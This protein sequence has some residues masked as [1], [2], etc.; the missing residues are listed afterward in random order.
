MKAHYVFEDGLT[1]KR[2]SSEDRRKDDRVVDEA[3]S[4][5]CGINSE[6]TPP[7]I[8]I[9]NR[10]NE[11]RDG[12]GPLG[13]Q[14]LGSELPPVTLSIGPE[15][16]EGDGEVVQGCS[17]QATDLHIRRKNE[18]LYSR[19]GSGRSNS[20]SRHQRKIVVKVS[21]IFHQVATVSEQPPRVPGRGV[22]LLEGGT[23]PFEHLASARFMTTR[24]YKDCIPMERYTIS[25]RARLR[26][27]RRHHLFRMFESSGG[28]GCQ[29]RRL[30]RGGPGTCQTIRA[31]RGTSTRRCTA[32][33][34][35]GA[36]PCSTNEHVRGTST[37]L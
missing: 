30:R 23:F 21:I 15:A 9:I 1:R 12:G 17:R 10:S 36:C 33:S 6:T 19:G 34:T 3:D 35:R 7:A 31:L 13:N 27:R 28:A 11:F 22:H 29:T 18:L 26:P 16:V 8:S 32:T 4:T 24:P 5:L 14:L 25:C 20:T 2:R 37:A